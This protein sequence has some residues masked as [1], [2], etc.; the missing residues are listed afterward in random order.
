MKL[1]D[2]KEEDWKYLGAAKDDDSYSVTNESEFEEDRE[3]ET[4][5]ETTAE[6]RDIMS[7]VEQSQSMFGN[8]S[9]I[10]LSEIN[11]EDRSFLHINET[12]NIE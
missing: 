10:G 3:S 6:P 7:A 4:G 9:M 12:Q 2:D 1:I 11:K 8:I 5:I